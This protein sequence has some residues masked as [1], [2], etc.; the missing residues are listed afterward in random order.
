MKKRLLQQA[1]AYALDKLPNHP[2][3]LHFPHFSFIVARGK[4]VSWATNTRIEPPI[5]YGY[6]RSW[7]ETYKPKFHAEI[8]AYKKA[9]ISETFEIINIRLSRHGEIRLSKPCHPCCKLMTKLGCKRIWFSSEAGFL[10]LD[11]T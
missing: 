5:H 2:E 3:L 9:T 7:D 6:H 1:V 11:L 10:S 4:I 8:S